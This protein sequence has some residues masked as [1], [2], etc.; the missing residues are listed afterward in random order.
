[1]SPPAAKRPPAED[2]IPCTDE[3]LLT[4]IDYFVA[5]RD[6]R[7]AAE[8][9]HFEAGVRLVAALRSRG[10]QIGALI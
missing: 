10:I 7:N 1:M 3:E 9:V 5:T 6:A 4:A 2:P 8:A